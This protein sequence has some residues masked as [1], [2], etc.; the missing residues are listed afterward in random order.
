MYDD[1]Q[2]LTV[3]MFNAGVRSEN[4]GLPVKLAGEVLR[5][6]AGMGW[7]LDGTVHEVDLAG[8]HAMLKHLGVIPD[9]EL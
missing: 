4:N 6:L 2:A 8:N 9:D 5:L 1:K 3:A 7:R